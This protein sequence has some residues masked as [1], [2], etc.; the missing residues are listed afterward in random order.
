MRIPVNNKCPIGKEELESVLENSDSNKEAASYLGITTNSLTRLCRNFGIDSAYQ[1][2]QFS[3]RSKK[4]KV[5]RRFPAWESSEPRRLTLEEY[6][7]DKL[8]ESIS[9]GGS[10]NDEPIKN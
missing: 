9:E 5:I 8:S 6:N 10:V 3:K 1:R 7:K 4:D 2:R